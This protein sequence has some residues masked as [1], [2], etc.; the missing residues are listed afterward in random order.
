MIQIPSNIDQILMRDVSFD[1][2]AEETPANL[3]INSSIM[4]ARVMLLR[5]QLL[6]R[7]Y[8][9]YERFKASNTH[10]MQN[11]Q[12]YDIFAKMRWPGLFDLNN[13]RLVPEIP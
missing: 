12:D 1:L 4:R 6:K 5:K 13:P 11:A 8:S 3:P 2:A 7:V 9:E 10:M